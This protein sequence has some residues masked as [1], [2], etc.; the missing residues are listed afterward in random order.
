MYG[1]VI[2]T[3]LEKYSTLKDEDL[4]IY[5]DKIVPVIYQ[6]LKFYKDSATVW[7]TWGDAIVATYEKSEV[8]VNMALAY[9]DLFKELDFAE[10]GIRKL[11]PRIACHFGE[12][13][14]KFDQVSGSLNIHGTNVNLAA[15]IEPVTVP[16]EIFV[17]KDF[18]EMV[19]TGFN[20][21]DNVRFDDMGIVKLVKNSGE[22]HLFRLCR[23][24]DPP[25]QPVGKT[26]PAQNFSPEPGKSSA[27]KSRRGFK[28]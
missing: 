26:V 14:T 7:N 25:I 10:F 2:F 12:F 15:R 28:R 18:K 27:V 21:T 24:T 3:D 11:N 5:Y 9:R 13:E 19:C 16:G 17:T 1:Y 23:K 6:K 22:R 20:L 4:K 8:A